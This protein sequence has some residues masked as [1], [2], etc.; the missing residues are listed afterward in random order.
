MR[1]IKIRRKTINSI[2]IGTTG[3]PYARRHNEGLD[4]MPQREFIGDS[5]KLFKDI[6]KVIDK[7]ILRNL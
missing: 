4:N 5:D 3:V 2:T 7:Q 6:E 1:S